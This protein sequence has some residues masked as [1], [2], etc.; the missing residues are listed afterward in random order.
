MFALCCGENLH[1]ELRDRKGS[2]RVARA[3]AECVDLVEES[4][5]EAGGG[6]DDGL[7]RGGFWRGGFWRGGGY[8]CILL[9]VPM[10]YDAVKKFM[11]KRS[12]IIRAHAALHVRIRHK[13][14]RSLRRL[15]GVFWNVED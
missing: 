14:H 11:G 9:C 15:R 3:C 10:A 5:A 6:A 8:G 1:G 7:C 12:G 13:D 4:V 2:Y